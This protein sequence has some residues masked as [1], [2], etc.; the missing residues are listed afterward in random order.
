MVHV[1]KISKSAEHFENDQAL[2]MEFGIDNSADVASLPLSNA[3]YGNYGKPAVW[4]VA[5]DGAT[6]DL[7]YLNESGWHKIG[8]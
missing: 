4:S 3:E 5:L 6:G 7:Y 1:I 8:E 2:H